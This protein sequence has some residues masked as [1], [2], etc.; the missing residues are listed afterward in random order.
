MVDSIAAEVTAAR[1]AS[2]D[3]AGDGSVFRLSTGRKAL[4][5][6]GDL[7]DGIINVSLNTYLLFYLTEVVGLSGSLAGAAVATALI[8]DAVADPVIGYMTD[9]THSRWGRRHPYMLFSIFP[10]AIGFAALFAVPKFA[11]TPELFAYVLGALLV[12]RISYSTFILPY[13]ALGAE[14]SRDY[15]DRSVLMTFRSFFNICAN[16]SCIVMGFGIFMSGATG[17]LNRAGYIHFGWAGAAVILIGGLI[18]AASTVG[19]RAQLYQVAPADRSASAR[20]LGELRDLF[21]N[22][23]FTT[24]FVTILTFFV[25]AGTAI[26]LL[27]Y[28]FRYF[29]GMP[30][31]V[32]QP[33]ALA[34]TVG[35]IIGIPV[36]AILLQRFEKRDIC[37]I[38]IA[39]LCLCQFLPPVLKLAGFMPGL[40]LALYTI[41]GTVGVL[42]SC[43]ITSTAIA[44]GSM[45]IDA[46]DEHDLLFGVRREGL[47][48][49][50]L[51]FSVKAA[52][53]VGALFA[54]VALDVIGFPKDLAMHPN[55][56]I[57]PG[58]VRAI[59]LIAGPF[60]A[61]ICLTSALVLTRYRLTKENLL[62]VQRQLK[63]RSEAL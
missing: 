53:G 34:G 6:T 56:I 58:T 52:V 49:A 1:T 16:I 54:G 43:V 24:L 42:S 21:R 36:S 9:N 51:T 4:Y 11:T 25:A 18:S 5:A 60:T 14:L 39:L 17:L 2:E 31:S 46:A 38:G 33:L 55:A 35:L 45:L 23:S 50:S 59:G 40:G 20:F 19:F 22:S 27:I 47:Y 12:L 57:P 41:L 8:V 37:V 15:A 3:A 29:W 30:T 28:S 26:S 62:R 10:F 32:I 7:A 48:F 63:E 61:M 13:A 44:F